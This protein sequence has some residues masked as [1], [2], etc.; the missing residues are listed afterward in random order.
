MNWLWN[1]IEARR[2]L[3]MERRHFQADRF[4]GPLDFAREF[5]VVSF[6]G[7]RQSGHTTFIREHAS[8]RDLVVLPNA[9][10]FN[11]GYW[12]QG[13]LVVN[14]SDDPLDAIYQE[15]GKQPAPFFVR[16]LWIDEP[17]FT[18]SSWSSEKWLQIIEQMDPSGMIIALGQSK[19]L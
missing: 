17:A 13:I 12:R 5:R 18:T 2:R 11:N 10:T 6:N 7:G 3:M 4:F 1:V 16:D 9:M 19:L 8:P 14:Q 15:R